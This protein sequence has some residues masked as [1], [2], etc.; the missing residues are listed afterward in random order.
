MVDLS[1][2]TSATFLTI[3]VVLAS[4]LLAWT[5]AGLQWPTPGR[6]RRRTP[7][8]SVGPLSLLRA[9][10]ATGRY[11]EVIRYARRE[12]ASAATS[13]GASDTEDSLTTRLRIHNL[14]R[15]LRRLDRRMRWGNSPWWPSFDLLSSA[16][17]R[18]LAGALDLESKLGE[19]NRI[20][21]GRRRWS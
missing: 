19:V 14:G 16:G 21:E 15:R 1:L 6:L 11:A 3:A 9:A 20:A 18:T 12:L 7:M 4:V 2:L 13:R 5:V 17:Q 10:D 8:D